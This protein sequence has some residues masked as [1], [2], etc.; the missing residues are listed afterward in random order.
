MIVLAALFLVLQGSAAVGA[1]AAGVQDAAYS[2]DGRLALAVDG[3]IWVQRG[4]N[5]SSGGT[6]M[7]SRL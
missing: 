2:P 3:D 5:A 4:T 1:P 6:S 7:T